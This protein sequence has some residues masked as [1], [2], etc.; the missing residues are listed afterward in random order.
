MTIPLSHTPVHALPL[1]ATFAVFTLSAGFTL[2]AGRILHLRYVRRAGNILQ[3][4][5]SGNRA[6]KDH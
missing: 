6:D 1:V 3:A 5:K 2:K 4:K